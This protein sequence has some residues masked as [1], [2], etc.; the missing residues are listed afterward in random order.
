MM[1]IDVLVVF[2]LSVCM[3]GLF[4][5]GA[6]RRIG[7]SQGRRQAMTEAPLLFRVDAL[8]SGEC[9]VCNGSRQT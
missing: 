1:G 7:I 4:G 6:G 3:V 5:Y 9:P 8:Q 2:V